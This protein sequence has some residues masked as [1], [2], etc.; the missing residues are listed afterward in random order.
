MAL[1]VSWK[2]GR[3]NQELYQNLPPVTT[4]FQKQRMKLAAHCV[5]H[6]EEVAN[7]LVLWKPEGTRKRGRPAY[8]Y[9][10][11]LL[12]DTGLHNTNEL[13]M[14]MKDRKPV[15]STSNQRGAP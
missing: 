9:I 8:T 7:K 14:V 15:R 11:N 3:S 4:K 13:E 5:R 10:D 1:D 12:D 6:E 2:E